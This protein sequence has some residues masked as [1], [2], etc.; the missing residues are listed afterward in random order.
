V[1]GNAVLCF[2]DT[3]VCAEKQGVEVAPPQL[4][5]RLSASIFAVSII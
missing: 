1:I 5:P 4:L 3:C 2:L